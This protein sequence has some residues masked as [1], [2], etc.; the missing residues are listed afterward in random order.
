MIDLLLSQLADP[1]RIGLLI[2]LVLT[3][4]RNAPVS[5]TIIPLAAGV[6]FVAV[7]IPVA[8]QGG[9]DATRVGV[10]ILAN[11]ILLGVILGAWTLFQRLR[12]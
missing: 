7:L 10:G 5:G 4:L 8:M 2:A 9:F 3:M 6:V 11:A 12:G 1:F